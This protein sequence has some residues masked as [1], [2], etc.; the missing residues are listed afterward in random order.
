M[1]GIRTVEPYPFACF[2]SPSISG[3]S[4]MMHGNYFFLVIAFVERIL[5][6]MADLGMRWEDALPVSLGARRGNIWY[7]VYDC[8]SR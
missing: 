8:D 2:L 3:L 6:P 7:S 1:W 4:G 5:V